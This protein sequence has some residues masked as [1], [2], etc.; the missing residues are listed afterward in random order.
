LRT[1][2]SSFLI[3]SS[4]SAFFR[5]ADV[6]DGDFLKFQVFLIFFSRC[7]ATQSA[8]PFPTSSAEDSPSQLNGAQIFFLRRYFP[9][10]E[11]FSA[12]E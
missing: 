7:Y 9:S 3:F 5:F 4:L 1:T 6:V 2:F 10:S 12:P 8:S 11:R